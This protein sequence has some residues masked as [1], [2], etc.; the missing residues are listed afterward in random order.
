MI[1]GEVPH[2]PR[3]VMAATQIESNLEIAVRKIPTYIRYLKKHYARLTDTAFIA[4][5]LLHAC[6]KDSITLKNHFNIFWKTDI[7]E[8][9]EK[10]FQSKSQFHTL[11][12]EILKSCVYLYL[13]QKR[14]CREHPLLVNN[15]AVQLLLETID[16]IM[17]S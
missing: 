9:A 16:Q 14:L 2:F 7:Y 17:K 3:A 12:P 1:K 5:K 4:N 10:K 6:L 8:S 13:Q 11:Q 15:C